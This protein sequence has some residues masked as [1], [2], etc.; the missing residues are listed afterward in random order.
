MFIKKRKTQI[1]F[2]IIIGLVIFISI[3][4]VFYL[5]SSTAKK[6]VTKE[7]TQSKQTKVN[8]Q[9]IIE[10]TNQCLDQVSRKG[11]EILGK[12]AGYLF[13]TSNGLPQGGLEDESDDGYAGNVFLEH[14]GFKVVYAISNDY[15]DTLY[16]DY[17]WV[18]FPDDGSGNDVFSNPFE[19]SGPSGAPLDILGKLFGTWF[20]L[21]LHKEIGGLDSIQA[22]LEAYVKNN[23]MGCTNFNIFE[24]QGYEIT[25]KPEDM[26]VNMTI[27]LND[28]SFRLKYPLT[29]EYFDEKTTIQDFSTNHDIRLQKIYNV[30]KRILINDVN[31]IQ[32]NISS[33]SVVPEILITVQSDDVYLQDDIITVI[34]T[35]SKILGKDFEFRFARQNRKPALHYITSPIEFTCSPSTCTASVDEANLLSI[36]TPQT[37]DPD[38]DTPTYYFTDIYGDIL[39]LNTNPLTSGTHDIRVSVTDNEFT[40]SQDIQVVI[41]DA[42]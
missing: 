8:V 32:Y 41:N 31:D 9:P 5:V 40:D 28:V 22:N 2:I 36:I 24:E 27:G 39:D 7:A 13:K 17:P 1:T 30:V 6:Q 16:Q 33:D 12:Q 14:D 38:E 25:T 11:L 20:L 29:I 19:S 26:Y 23:L 34:D 37:S 15:L 18:T 21:E 4:F 35:Q 3:S 42:S 10:Y